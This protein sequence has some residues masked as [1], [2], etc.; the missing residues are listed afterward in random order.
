M[1]MT[2]LSLTAL[3]V[4]VGSLAGCEKPP[5]P[6]E[7]KEAPAQPTFDEKAE[8]A[9]INK[10][11]DAFS[12]AIAE[13]RYGDLKGATT[14]DVKVAPPGCEEW[15]KMREAGKDRGPFPYDKIEMTPIETVILN[16]DTAYDFGN[17]KVYFKDENGEE[18][19]LTDTFLVIL[20]K[21]DGQWKL[22]REVGSCSV[23]K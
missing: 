4:F 23:V 13:K 20:K 5:P 19:V 3:A 1:R 8:V 14:P 11:R 12:L 17:S 9:A 10:L 15:Q 18:H 22:H 21:V 7:V 6:K 2:L 16:H